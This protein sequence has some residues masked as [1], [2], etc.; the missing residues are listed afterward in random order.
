VAS[1][2]ELLAHARAREGDLL[3]FA[4]ALV[5]IPSVNGRDSEAALARRIHQEV[6]RL[7]LATEWVFADPA[8]PN[9]L[10]RWGGGPAGF[11]LIGHMDTVAEGDGASWDHP[12]FAG[13][14]AGGRL[15]GR[16][17]ADNKAGLACGLY[18]LAL[19]RDHDLLD[20]GQAQVVLACVADEESGASSPFGVRYLLDTGR[21]R[22]R[23]AVYTYASD[24]VCI[25]HR[26]L[27]RLVLSAR[28]QAAHTGSR[29]WTERRQ[30]VNAVT[31][32][33][34][35][36]LRLESL[37]LPAPAHP[38]FEG[39]GCTLTPGTLFH[40]GEFESMVP[41][42]ASALVDVRLMPGQDEDEVL[43][44]VQAAIAAETAARPGLAVDI[45]VK[46]R[47][48]GAAIDA[49][50]PLA[51]T[52]QELAQALTGRPWPIAGA[53]PANEGYM[54]IGAGIPTLPGFGPRGGNAHAPNEWV[55]VDSLAE[56]TAIYAGLIQAY[57][58]EAR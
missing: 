42:T 10:V 26:G 15:F 24:I 1:P 32:L 56:T 51:V 49:G 34:A 27:L 40:G 5:R 13:V 58:S 45:A 22:A 31:G 48:P 16:G 4:Q 21:L 52:A 23:G 55:A 35:I 3:A 30:G 11:A 54:L 50:H 6:Q 28:G 37:D 18:T 36:L 7:G 41:A 38:A 46:N 44:V 17:A 29:E 9:L 39:L 12:P 20:P 33:S 2:V 8:R 53:G 57:L 43:Q 47:L 14:V 25:G 19:L